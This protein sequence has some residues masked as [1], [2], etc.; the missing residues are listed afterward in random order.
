MAEPIDLSSFDDM[1]KRQEEGVLVPIYGPDGKASLGFSIRVAGPDSERAQ[2]ALEAL[3][4]E[5]IEQESMQPP[6]QREIAQRRLRYFAK[7]TMD[8]VPD[9]QADGTV[10]EVAI[11]LDGK[12]LPCTE[13]NA[14]KLYERFKFILAQVK[15]KADTRSAFLNG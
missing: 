2:V 7:V 14:I 11:K 9:A 6:T 8:F 4:Q 15:A 5:I 13:E 1:V 3:Q 10:P 12:P